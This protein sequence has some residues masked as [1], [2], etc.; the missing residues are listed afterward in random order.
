[1]TAPGHGGW[2]VPILVV[3]IAAILAAGWLPPVSATSTGES[4]S[5]AVQT[6]AF[7]NS[8]RLGPSTDLSSPRVIAGPGPSNP[9]Q[10][11]VYVLG[12]NNTGLGPCSNLTVFRSTDGGAS[13]ISEFPT[14]VCLP[15]TAVDAVVLPN[16]TLVV[17]AAGPVILRSSDG[18]ADWS[19]LAVLSSS[20]SLPS[21]YIDL[22]T[23][24]LFVAWTGA[25]GNSTGPLFVA[26]S[27]DGGALWSSPSSALPAQLVAGGAELAAN[28]S[29]VAVAF[30]ELATVELTCPPPSGNNSTQ[31][32]PTA[33]V[34]S[35][36]AVAS[37][38]GGASWGEAATIVPE[39]LSLVIGTPSLAVSPTGVFGIAWA[40]D[41]GTPGGN[42]VFAS[43]S[44]DGGASWSSPVAVSITAP[45]TTV[46]TTFGHTAAFD[47]SGRLYVTWFNY[48]ATNPFG[49]QLNVAIS[50]RSLDSFTPSSFN[51]TFRS[52]VGNSS[53]SENLAV[54][55]SGQVFLAWEV[56]GPWDEP[57]YGV[58]VRTVAGEAVGNLAGTVGAASVALIDASTGVTVG[59]VSWSG[60]PFTLSGL[61]ADSYQVWVTVANETTLVGRIPVV[62]W[63]ATS[64]VVKGVVGEVTSGSPTAFPYTLVIIGA[65]VVAAGAATTVA[66]T[67][68][69]RDTV[70][71]QKLRSL[72]YEYIQSEPGAS[73]SAVRDALGLQNGTT[74][75]HLAVLEREG[76]I[77]SVVRGHRRF[78]FPVGG[79]VTSR[80]PPLSG[81]QA[82]ILK[83]V[84]TSP[85]LGLRELSR[86]VGHEPSSVAYSARILAREGLLTTE[87]AG[88]R[89]R[90]YPPAASAPP[91]PAP[92][93]WASPPQN[94]T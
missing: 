49:G 29:A 8:I 63:G 18:G 17:A 69:T 39:N 67:R 74:S 61:M 9:T 37:T 56:P 53:Q 54:D 4:V 85:G 33:L 78:F 89:I 12:L 35:L 26:V 30:L 5:Y 68:L 6:G 90:F 86:A 76:F 77:Q 51:L 93:S 27:A 47:S 55:S 60:R 32:C 87:R 38:D 13:F 21:L 16:G 31:S 28:A 94:G 88:L 3:T 72:I 57:P 41:N 34:A 2:A 71:R 62:P 81:I 40:Q 25:P 42:G 59:R 66:Y 80:V 43:V 45:P 84:E 1:M 7:N 15:G 58:F 70:L 83:T 44:R 20:T 73:F 23:S 82:S 14:G 24:Q 11:D 48:S 91:P 52:A 10:Q 79:A 22:T 64:F 36:V 65:S 75:Y 19:R 92:T 50:N 46:P